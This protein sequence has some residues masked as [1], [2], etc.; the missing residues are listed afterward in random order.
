MSSSPAIWK[1]KSPTQSDHDLAVNPDIEMSLE[2]DQRWLASLIYGNDKHLER[3]ILEQSDKPVGWATFFVHPSAL[4][5]NLSNWT[6]YSRRIRRYTLF[7][8]PLLDNHADLD[9]LNVLQNL[10]ESLRNQLG[11]NEAIFLQSVTDG[12]PLAQLFTKNSPLHSSYHIF[13]YGQRYSHR[14]IDFTGDYDKY[15]KQL[16]S[17]TRSD[18]KRTRK[19]FIDSV[20]TYKTICYRS[21]DEI[22]DFLDAAMTVSARTYQYILLGGGL[23]DRQHLEKKYETTAKLGWFRSYVLFADQQPIAFQVG[24]LYNGCY[25]AQEI[26]YDPDWGKS[27]AG[28]FLHTEIVP[29]L[30]ASNGKVKRFDFG[31]DDNLHKKRLST[32][33]TTESYVYLVPRN[34]QNN[35]IV[36][37]MRTIDKLSNAAGRLLEKYNLRMH[38]SKL[39]WKFGGKK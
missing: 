38:V 25:H 2:Q 6:L 7:A 4:R 16:G 18:L 31:N 21:S 8:P 9:K 13:E 20:G 12:S 28:I 34:W 19:R 14:Y 23:R 39:L 17:S 15:L 1:K 35:L 36:Y 32:T 5:I 33:A 10:F 29:D 37:A 30:I 24:H 3:F 27:Q 22:S 26:G 11:Q